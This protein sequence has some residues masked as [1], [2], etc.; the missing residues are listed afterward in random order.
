MVLNTVYE[1]ESWEC[2]IYFRWSKVM[3]NSTRCIY[4]TG[5]DACWEDFFLLIDEF[6]YAIELEKS[7]LNILVKELMY[8]Q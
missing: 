7:P 8:L 1:I 5:T 2:N 6:P 4:M 3:A